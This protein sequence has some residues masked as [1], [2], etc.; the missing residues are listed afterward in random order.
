MT[1]KS[2]DHHGAV[3]FE[4]ACASGAVR[5]EL[6]GWDRLF[7]WRRSL[8]VGL[9][10]VQSAFV[11]SHGALEADIDHR[12]AGLGAHNGAKR[13]GRRPVLRPRCC[14]G[15]LTRHEVSANTSGEIC[16]DVA[17]ALPCHLPPALHV[18]HNAGG[19]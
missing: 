12:A 19:P 8:V 15:E 13:P 6:S 14:V 16:V 9:A 11:E 4:V 5:V 10:T 7:T 1:E 3:A 18:I 17:T 2:C